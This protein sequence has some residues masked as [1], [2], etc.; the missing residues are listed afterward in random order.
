MK[1]TTLFGLSTSALLLAGCIGGG[2]GSSSGGSQTGQMSLGITDA[3]VDDAKAVVIFV[4]SVEVKPANGPS[5]TITFDQAQEI[6]L[7]QYQGEDVFTLFTDEELP[8]GR[9]NWIR[10]HLQPDGAPSLDPDEIP[11]TSYVLL[12]DD[13]RFNLTVRSQNG[14]RLV[15]GFT[16]TAN[17]TTAYT[18]DVDLRR[19]LT[20]P[21]SDVFADTYFLRPALRLVRNSDVGHLFGTVET[22]D[23]A[24]LDACPSPSVYVFDGDDQTAPVDVDMS[25]D[26]G[27]VTTALV[28]ESDNSFRVG[29]L[30]AGDYSLALTCNANDDDPEQDDSDVVAFSAL[31][32][33]TVI[34]GESVEVET[35][36]TPP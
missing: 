1:L 7:L 8:A 18:L 35:S 24:L 27:P 36:L 13:K 32:D 14:L 3:P 15:S 9:Y 2:S 33:V 6:D 16:V 29:F 28:D 21:R 19:A 20:K 12:E 23:L 17:E 4:T 22:G 26:V 10:L 34:A 30:P 5:R 25:S 11:T 31:V